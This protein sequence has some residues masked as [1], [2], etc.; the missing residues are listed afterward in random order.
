VI[1]AAVTRFEGSELDATGRQWRL[2]VIE[3]TDARLAITGLP[4]DREER[5][6]LVTRLR[7][8][9]AAVSHADDT[10]RVGDGMLWRRYCREAFAA[11]QAEV[12]VEFVPAERELAAPE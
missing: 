4:E 10:D 8:L 9:L 12:T 1:A 3:C 7:D 6:G 11:W 2:V 5:L